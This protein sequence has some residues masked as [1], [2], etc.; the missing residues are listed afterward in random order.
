MVQS[1]SEERPEIFRGHF[2]ECFKHLSRRFTEKFARG[3]R[4]AWQAK[5]PFAAFCGCQVDT[6]ANW[7]R[8]GAVPVGEGYFKLMF[9]LDMLGYKI[10]EL[11]RMP[12]VQHNFAE[13]VGFG[14]ISGQ[15]AAELLGYVATSKLYEVWRGVCGSSEEKEQ[16]MYE[17]WK[18]RKEELAQK[19][20]RACEL[21]H[22]DVLS[23]G[24]SRR[25]EK[26][27]PVAVVSI[28]QGLLTLLEDDQLVNLT[29]SDANTVLQLSARLSTLSS[30]LIMTDQRKEGD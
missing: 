19:K 18:K 27:K 8:G 13:L 20:E 4:E 16:K 2:D 15:Q 22:F 11:E 24:G 17:E 3:T 26:A 9:F 7:L 6:V 25:V 12:K 10:I 28:M 29:P 14:L 5:E 30:Q 1:Q 21:Y 23:S